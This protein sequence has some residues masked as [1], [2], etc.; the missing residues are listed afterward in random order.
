M[1]IM[2]T[3]SEIYG[4]GSINDKASKHMFCEGCGYCVTCGDCKKDGCGKEI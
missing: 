1:I 3:E 2:K 4:D